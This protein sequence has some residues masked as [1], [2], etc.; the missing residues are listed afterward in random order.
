MPYGPYCRRDLPGSEEEFMP[1]QPHEEE[2]PR[3]KCTAVEPSSDG[4]GVRTD[5]GTTA[6]NEQSRSAPHIRRPSP[7]SRWIRTTSGCPLK[8]QLHRD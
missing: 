2:A 3:P 7:S 1:R 6:S 4:Y 5:D 8:Q